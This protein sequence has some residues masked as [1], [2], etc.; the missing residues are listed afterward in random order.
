MRAPGDAHRLCER[1]EVA[2]PEYQLMMKV[3]MEAM[4]LV[5]EE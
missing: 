1:I 4:T 5:G 2:F 3:V